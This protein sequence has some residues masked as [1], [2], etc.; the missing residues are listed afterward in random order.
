MK[1]S[2]FR[3]LGLLLCSA[4]LPSAPVFAQAPPG[5]SDVAS[6]RAQA[7]GD[8]V[9]WDIVEGITT[10]VGPRPAASP[11]EALAREWAVAELK[12]LG[13]ANVRS[14]PYTMKAWVRGEERA[15]VV[16]PFEQ[17]LV[18]ATLGNSGS[19][20]PKGL[21]AEVVLF[22]D[23]AAL[24]AAPDGSLKGK[25]AYVTHTMKAN[26]DGS[27]Y[28]PYGQ[29]RRAGPN[30]AAK[31]GASAILIRSIGT[32]S[33]RVAHTGVTTFEPGVTPIPAAAL[34]I[35]DADNIERMAKRGKPLR[36]H[37]LLTPKILENQPSGNVI[38]EVPGSDPDAGI[39]VVAGHLDSWD[40]GTGAVDDGAGIAIVA[41]AAKR[42]M[43]AGQPRRTIRILWAGA[44]EVGGDGA[45]AYFARHSSEKHVLAMES[46]F[47]ADR[48]WRVNFALP[49]SA[50][51]VQERISAALAPLGIVVG[52][53]KAGDGADIEPLIAS[54]VSGIDL[55]QEGTRYFDL[56]HTPDDTL[57]K[58]DPAQLAQNV[59]AW[60]T[61]LAV[62]A[63]AQEPLR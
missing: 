18:I 30:I 8:T 13:F 38:A 40:Q 32:D 23:L 50:K 51:A 45:R 28:G 53:D 35:P 62:A 7:L 60:V 61:V 31:K 34:S 21:D 27:G 12:S 52:H 33:H 14:E 54:G 37:L 6:L 15:Q 48:V 20:G 16:A 36:V 17:P 46:D 25:I 5:S 1:I 2:S 47:G 58:I 3:V 41:A 63:N 10:E 39:I 4:V 44:E 49:E 56:H 55:G 29:V 22:S 11:K 9:A 26:Q 42:I 24:T 57:D 43:D 59:A 19:T